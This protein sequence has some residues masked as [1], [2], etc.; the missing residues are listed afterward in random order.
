VV[1]P[2]SY[3]ADLRAGR[4]AEVAFLVGP[5]GV[6]AVVRPAVD[7]AVRAQAT[8]VQAARFAAAHGGGGFDAALA[9]VAQLDRSLRPPRITSRDVGDTT[10]EF[11]GLRQFDLG[12]STQLLLFVFITGITGS[13]AVIQARQL[14][15][16]RRMLSTPTPMGTVLG[17]MTLSRFATTMLEGVYIIV[18]TMVL[19][20]VNWGDPAGAI[21]VLVSF[22]LVATGVA[23]LSGA[24]F[25]NDQ[26]ASSVGVFLGLGLGALGGC[27]FPLELFTGPMRVVAHVTPH[28][29]ANDAFGELVRHDAGLVDI[30]PNLAVLLGMAAVL[31]TVATWRLR[32]ALTE[33]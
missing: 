22:A 9:R 30:L 26:Q 11:E 6:G 10:D 16:A 1:I 7:E 15:V 33:G 20:A 31:L 27:M 29:W 21:A 5:S 17:G 2:A 3:G 8:R 14:G 23:M 12:A 13:S 4:Q 18:A 19:F 28:A 24:V 25:R 32:K